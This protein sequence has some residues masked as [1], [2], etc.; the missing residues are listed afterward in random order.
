LAKE[1]NYQ[2]LEEYQIKIWLE[3]LQ[4]NNKLENSKDLNKTLDNNS[5][6]ITKF[7]FLSVLYQLPELIISGLSILFL[8]LYYQIYCG[9]KGGLS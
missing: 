5:R 4:P 9:G 3:G 6:K 7:N 2:N 8:F 1:N